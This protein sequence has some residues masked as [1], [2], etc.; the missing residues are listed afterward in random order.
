MSNL[1]ALTLLLTLFLFLSL[2]IVAQSQ[3]WNYLSQQKS[4][5]PESV[6]NS[7]PEVSPLAIYNNKTISVPSLDN[8]P[9]QVLGDTTAVNQKRIEVDLTAQRLYAYEGDRLV[10]NFLISSGKWNRTPTGTFYIWVKVRS[11]KMEGGSKA[12][13]DYYYLPNVPYV[14]F[15]YNDKIAKTQG[16]SLHGTYWHHNFGVPMSHGCINMK[17]EEIKELYSW[18]TPDLHGKSGILA[19]PD[20]PGTPIT[21][22]GKYIY[23]TK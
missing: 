20:N 15:F 8:Q 1:R 21:I 22:Y 2:I 11:T 17:T 5:D 13:G 10:Y 6:L 14:M 19:T 9:P 7:G 3:P 18:A 12:L 23:P 4:I 16:F